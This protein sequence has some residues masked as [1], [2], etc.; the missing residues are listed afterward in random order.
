MEKAE[1]HKRAVKFGG[2]IIPAEVGSRLDKAFFFFFVFVLSFFFLLT[3]IARC[4]Q[5]RPHLA[6]ARVKKQKRTGS[7]LLSRHRNTSGRDSAS[8]VT[9]GARSATTSALSSKAGRTVIRK[10][11]TLQKRLSQALVKNDVETARTVQAE[12]EANGGLE[13]YQRASVWV[14]DLT[15]FQ[16]WLLLR[17]KN[18]KIVAEN[19][20]LQVCGQSSQRGGDSSKILIDWIGEIRQSASKSKSDLSDNTTGHATEQRLRLLEVGALSPDNACSK[21]SLFDVK[22]IDL[23]SR[24][25]SIETQDFMERPLPKHD[26]ERFDIISLSLVLNYVSLPMGR[27][28][29]LRRTTKFLRDEPF[30]QVDSPLA[31]LFPSLFLVLPAP[32]VTNSRYLNHDRLAEIMNCLG[33]TLVRS[34]LSAK[35]SYQLWRFKSGEMKQDIFKKEEIN[36]GK[37]RNN[38]AIVL[39]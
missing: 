35:L 31:E 24:H 29:M 12:I 21:S 33:Y 39:K 5:H 22:R 6:M 19:A 23:N 37:A 17:K 10:H 36:P 32:C 2:Q 15:I 26:D 38:F 7:I 18:E 28:A 13:K 1:E 11:H 8:L 20:S 30:G 27:G 9:H 14:H 16:R 3:C 34:K 25:P 4:D